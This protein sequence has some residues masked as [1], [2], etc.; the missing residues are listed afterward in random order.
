L[1]QFTI[2][3]N[4]L[5]N[6]FVMMLIGYAGARLH[7]LDEA[8]LA[9]ISRLIIRL[10]LPILIFANG[11]NQTTRAQLLDCWPILLLTAGMYAGLITL[12]WLLARLQGLS[13][14][15]GKVYRADFIFGN[16]GFLG[17]PLIPVIFPQNGAI[18]LVVMTVID[19]IF[20]W[21]YGDWLTTPAGG[22]S[23]FSFRNF[24]NPALGAVVLSVIL[25]MAGIRFPAVL[26]TPLL[27]VGRSSAPLSLIYLGGLLHF[28]DWKRPFRT[29]ELYLGVL[30]KQILY[31]LAF[32]FIA[33]LLCPNQEMVRMMTMIS[34]LPTMT[35]IAMF[36]ASKNN[37]GEYAIGTVLATTI[38]SLFT[39]SFVSFVIFR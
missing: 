22:S 29:L 3:L 5:F 25:V 26:C 38:A 14:D 15:H 11:V 18:Y 33:G 13:G 9:N 35:T 23:R 19:Q 24:L 32:Y 28:V 12:F 20:V 36:A 16:I 21:T 31:P 4:Q 17:L 37:Q 27:T 39:L 7:I 8:L 1:E 6:F 30:F 34:A 2:V 10:I